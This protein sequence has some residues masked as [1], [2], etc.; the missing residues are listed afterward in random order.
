MWLWGSDLAGQAVLQI[1]MPLPAKLLA[2]R[3]AGGL[4]FSTLYVACFLNPHLKK[5]YFHIEFGDQRQGVI[6]LK[7]AFKFLWEWG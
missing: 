1:Q 7:L 4:G 3:P 5:R 6:G 2:G